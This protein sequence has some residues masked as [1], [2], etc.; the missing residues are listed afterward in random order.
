M[1][2]VHWQKLVIVVL[3]ATVF[4]ASRF[5]RAWVFKP[6]LDEILVPAANNTLEIEAVEARIWQIGIL[7]FG[8]PVSYT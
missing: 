2:L 4:A 5:I 8:T 3:L 1:S 6:L 7:V